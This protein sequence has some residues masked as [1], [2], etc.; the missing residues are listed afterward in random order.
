MKLYDVTFNIWLISNF[1]L[2]DFEQLLFDDSIGDCIPYL[3]GII[4]H[5]EIVNLQIV[6]PYRYCELLLSYYA[7]LNC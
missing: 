7:T 6:Q 5:L 4:S 3:R 2:F 1:L